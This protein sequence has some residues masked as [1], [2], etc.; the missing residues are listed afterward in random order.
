MFLNEYFF[1]DNKIKNRKKKQMP[2]SHTKT[3]KTYL[4]DYS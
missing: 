1:A 2:H 3:I 4:K